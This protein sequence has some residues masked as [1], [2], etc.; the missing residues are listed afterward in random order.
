M[1][2]PIMRELTP[3]E[4]LMV[5]GGAAEDEDA[6]VGVTDEKDLDLQGDDEKDFAADQCKEGDTHIK[7][8]FEIGGFNDWDWFNN[9]FGGDGGDNLDE[10]GSLGEEDDN[11]DPG[12]VAP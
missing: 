7:I 5:S 1:N 11:G 9:W 3:E 8:K 2:K 10:E 6:K 4:L 12:K